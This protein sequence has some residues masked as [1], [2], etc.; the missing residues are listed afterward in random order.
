MEKYAEQVRYNFVLRTRG[1]AVSDYGLFS[2]ERGKEKG[3]YRL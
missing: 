3:T 2:R 1:F